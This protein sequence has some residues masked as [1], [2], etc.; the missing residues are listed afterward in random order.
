[1]PELITYMINTVTLNTLCLW[2]FDEEEKGKYPGE[3]RY[4]GPTY[5]QKGKSIV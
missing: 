3:D 5:K 2:N 1:M 4:S